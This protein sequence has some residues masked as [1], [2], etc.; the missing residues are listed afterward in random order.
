[1]A[2]LHW[3]QWQEE[4]TCSAARRTD[5]NKHGRASG[6]QVPWIWS[7]PL[8]QPR[9]RLWWE[10]AAAGGTQRL[11]LKENTTPAESPAKL[12]ENKTMNRL[13]IF[14]CKVGFT[15]FFLQPGCKMTSVISWGFIA[16]HMSPCP[17]SSPKAAQSVWYKDPQGM[18]GGYLS[19]APSQWFRISSAIQ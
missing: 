12:R 15:F 4:P 5:K 18:T 10:K 2:A 16:V 8:A 13:E 17:E 9:R 7:V 11:P 3:C 19:R 6:W 1:M 14:W